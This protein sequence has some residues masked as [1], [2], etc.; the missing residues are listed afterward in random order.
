MVGLPS[1]RTWSVFSGKIGFLKIES[2]RFWFAARIEGWPRGGRF[3]EIGVRA[4][5]VSCVR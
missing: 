3:R 4:V 2:R 5:Y 1:A